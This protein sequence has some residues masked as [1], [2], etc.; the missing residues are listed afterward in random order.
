MLKPAKLSQKAFN[1]K[2]LKHQELDNTVLASI[3]NA[4]A[5]DLEDFAYYPDGDVPKRSDNKKASLY[6]ALKGDAKHFIFECKAAS[7]SLGD[8]N[9]NLNLKELVKVYSKT[10][11]AISVLCEKHFFKGSFENLNFVKQ[12]THLPVICKDFIVDKRQ[13]YKAAAKGADAVLLMCSVLDEEKLLELYDCA[14]NL[15]LEALVEVHDKKEALF[16]LKQDFPIVGINN[17]NL[18]TL[19]I[20]FNI[21]RELAFLKDKLSN[22]KERVVISESG[23]TSPSDIVSLDPVN[24]FLIGSTICEEINPCR[25]TAAL[26]YGFNKI[27]GLKDQQAL[28][29]VIAGRSATMAGFV[30]VPGSPRYITAEKAKDLITATGALEYLYTVG[31]FLDEKIE[32]IKEAVQIA[33]FDYVQLHGSESLSYVM[34]LKKALP[35]IKII[36]ALKGEDPDLRSQAESF[37]GVCD[38]IVLDS[39]IPGSGVG[40]AWEGIGDAVDRS[41][42]LLSGG[43]NLDNIEKALALNFVGLDLSS[44]AES[45]RGF[46]DPEKITALL[47]KIRCKEK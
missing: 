2:G 4:K 32:T 47:T 12:N 24:N 16:A 9:T 33:G 45:K 20:D 8:I 39:S 10:A 13:I 22:G 34:E 44:G 36:K 43:I 11:N 7:P 28:E 23:I 15:S 5:L 17:R 30:L 41:R 29:A 26:K 21:T 35:D 31:V 37:L 40:F 1:L 19:K 25:K 46:K 6:E 38:L 18:K 3:I 27:C 42:T 14:K